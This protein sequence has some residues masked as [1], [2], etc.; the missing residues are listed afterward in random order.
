MTPNH[1][2]DQIDVLVVDDDEGVRCSVAAVLSDAGYVVVEAEDGQV[3]LA[4]LQSRAIGAVLLDL[5]M[6]NLDGIG[7]LDM[8]DDP[9]PTVIMTAHDYDYDVMARRNKIFR[10]VQKPIPPTELLSLVAAALGSRAFGTL[11]SDAPRPTSALH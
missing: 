9:P 11:G 5:R 8:L 2:A 6:P 10:Y 3:A 1:H 4:H 7:L